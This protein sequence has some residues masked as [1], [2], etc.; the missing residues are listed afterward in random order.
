MRI[1]DY[2][3][4]FFTGHQNIEKYAID[5]GFFFSKLFKVLTKTSRKTFMGVKRMVEI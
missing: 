2:T 4:H 3:T 5:R 1:R